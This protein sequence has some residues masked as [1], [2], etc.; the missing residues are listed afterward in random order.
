MD[1]YTPQLLLFNLVKKHPFSLFSCFV[2]YFLAYTLEAKKDEVLLSSTKWNEILSLNAKGWRWGGEGANFITSLV[3]WVL[4]SHLWNEILWVLWAGGK[5]GQYHTILRK[6]GT[7]R[8]KKCSTKMLRISSLFS[9]KKVAVHPVLT[10]FMT[11]YCVSTIKQILITLSMK[12]K[13]Q[14]KW[15]PFRLF[16]CIYRG[17]LQRDIQL[18]EK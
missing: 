4:R 13:W 1:L 14:K 8:S 6:T 18:L 15:S 5:Q 2:A 10:E 9:W 16:L 12:Y 3:F 17:C 7:H 11:L